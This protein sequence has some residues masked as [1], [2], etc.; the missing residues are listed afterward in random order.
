[1]ANLLINTL[2]C[3]KP[4]DV[5]K[6]SSTVQI[7]AEVNKSSLINSNVVKSQSNVLP[8]N[9]G[10]LLSKDKITIN[11]ILK[12]PS[13]K[14]K[15][16]ID[17]PSKTI[18]SKNINQS[19]KPESKVVEKKKKTDC[20]DPIIKELRSTSYEQLMEKISK[21]PN[22]QKIYEE[23]FLSEESLINKKEN[24]YKA[25]Q[26][27]R[28]KDS[29]EVKNLERIQESNKMLEIRNRLNK[30]RYRHQDD[31]ISRS[32]PAN[33]VSFNK[34]NVSYE[35]EYCSECLIYHKLG[36]HI[37]QKKKNE[38]AKEKLNPD[39]KPTI[40]KTTQIFKKS[41]K[42]IKQNILPINKVQ[43]QLIMQRNNRIY[44][45]NKHNQE[46]III[47]PHKLSDNQTKNEKK[48]IPPTRNPREQIKSKESKPVMT[49]K[50]SEKNNWNRKK[51]VL[52]EEDDENSLDDFI[53]DDSNTSFVQ[54]EL[55]K[56]KKGYRR[57]N[58]SPT[59]IKDD[60]DDDIME[61]GFDEIQREEKYSERQAEREDEMEELR[62]KMFYNKKKNK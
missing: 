54:Q 35:E 62:E 44:G 37:D 59:D 38:I 52:E 60:Y 8:K 50:N 56:I 28:P 11:Q 12:T 20:I 3:D 7:K 40:Q 61:A 55:R 21:D 30:K 23:K 24:K 10:S 42:E 39:K 31:E 51:E 48:L 14:P 43:E 26:V 4:K 32:I 16:N 41:K 53:E 1:M 36:K 2:F 57:N 27:Y 29:E 49:S 45:V 5:K 6:S 46:S 19:V 47:K 15:T 18:N 34:S 33:K 17:A 9:N 22:L 25:E 13:V 58:Y